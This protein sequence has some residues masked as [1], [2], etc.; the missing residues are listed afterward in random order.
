MT[1]ALYDAFARQIRYLRV[2][3]TDRCNLRCIYCMPEEGIPLMRHEDILRFEEIRRL[4]E[5][6]IGLGITRVRLTGGEPLARRGVVELVRML[7]ALPGLEDLALTTNGTLLAPLA[8]DLAR[9]GLRRVNISLDTLRPERYRAITRRGELSDALAG[10][11]AAQRAGLDPI[12]INMVVMRAI[13][14][15]EVT[16]LARLSLERGWHVRFIEYMPLGREPALARERFVSMQ[17][18]RARLEETLGPLEPAHVEGSGPA[19][20]WRLA[21]AP[22]MAGTIGFISALSEHFCATCNRLRLSA[23]GRLFP[24]LFSDVELDVRTPLRRGADDE[25]LRQVFRQAVAAKGPGHQLDRYVTTTSHTMS[26][27]GG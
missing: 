9:A 4:V 2:S 11:E 10:I 24:C 21:G 7:A 8:E 3:I 15:D 27:I 22:P 19:R 23:D 12:K 18:V 6:A 5:I 1:G 20:T 26:R 17:E 16:D 25:A 14:D 13:N